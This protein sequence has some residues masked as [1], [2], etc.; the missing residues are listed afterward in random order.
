MLIQADFQFQ[1]LAAQEVGRE[2]SASID[3]KIVQAREHIAEVVGERQVQVA[4]SFDDRN[5]G[6]DS[7]SGLFTSD[8]YPISP[9]KSYR[10]HRVLGQVVAPSRFR[11]QELGSSP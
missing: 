7:W 11:V 6:G 2:F 1:I 8:V 10:A 3:R 4:T 5:D 9:A